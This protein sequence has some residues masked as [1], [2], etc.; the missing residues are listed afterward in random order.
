MWVALLIAFTPSIV[1][2]QLSFKENNALKTIASLYD[3]TIL[4]DSHISNAYYCEYAKHGGMFVSYTDAIGILLSFGDVCYIPSNCMIF[5]PINMRKSNRDKSWLK[6]IETINDEIDNESFYIRSDFQPEINSVLNAFK[7][8]EIHGP[9]NRNNYKY[10]NASITL[11]SSETIKV[12]FSPKKRHENTTN[13]YEGIMYYNYEKNKIDSIIVSKGKKYSYQYERFVYG[14]IKIKYGWNG[15]NHWPQTIEVGYKDRNMETYSRIVLLDNNPTS[16][17]L[18]KSD[19]DY[20][21]SAQ[22]VVFVNYHKQQ[23]IEINLKPC[24]EFYDFIESE[25][26]GSKNIEMQFVNNSNRPFAIKKRKNNNIHPPN[27]WEVFEY[28]RKRTPE[29]LELLPE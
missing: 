27:D 24:Y 23:W 8:F 3:N 26:G 16:T 29:L 25:I 6:Y 1:F 12:V 7:W 22:P 13:H 19:F 4:K 2:S 5:T 11:S 21:G 15:M 28:I 10:F 17:S 14:S 9:L 18:I 20:Y